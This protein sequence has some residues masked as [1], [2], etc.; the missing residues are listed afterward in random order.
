MHI[1]P[2]IRIH[3]QHP[4]K[5]KALKRT[6][7]LFIVFL[8]SLLTFSMAGF[9][10]VSA[11]PSPYPTGT[12]IVK[13]V[14]VN[15]NGGTKVASDFTMHVVGLS[16]VPSGGSSPDTYSISFPGDAVGQPVLL[17]VGFYEVTETQLPG[18]AVTYS[19]ECSSSTGG[20]FAEGETRTCTITNSDIGPTLNVIV[21]VSNDSGGTKTP[22][23]FA[24][25]V[26]SSTTPTSNFPGSSLGT[27]VNLYSGAYGVGLSE[28]SNYDFSYSA[29]CSGSLAI[30]DAVTCT[31]VASDKA[32]SEGGGGG[33]SD[34]VNGDIAITKTVS[35]NSVVVNEQVVYTLTLINNGPQTATSVSV[36]DVLSP[37]LE[38][39]SASSSLGSYATTTGVW[40]VGDM[41]NGQSAVLEITVNIKSDAAETTIPNAAT[42]TSGTNDPASENNTSSV[43][44]SVSSGGSGG[45]SG[46]G[47]G[48]GPPPSGGG[49]SSGGS[50]VPS[51]PGSGGGSV[52]GVS[53]TSPQTAQGGL[54]MP[55]NSGGQVL[56]ESVTSELPRTGSGLWVLLACAM[57]AMLGAS[58]LF[59]TR[60]D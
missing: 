57:A 9:G 13:K 43:S 31:I 12:V 17:G 25:T 50:G 27:V 35:K 1:S 58:M 28:D 29:G 42:A 2:K 18:Y 20:L 7:S 15:N 56:G 53:T 6:A 40:T 60:F 21:Q 30:G 5:P 48:G 47:S 14:V 41:V 8:A 24:V 26:V 32:G 4:K 34:G 33:S 3:I 59:K 16:G 19:P 10:F 44:V 46:S 51:V 38:F 23:D 45:S 54:S 39:V 37:N 11:D 36:S 22:A 49:S 52:L 55:N